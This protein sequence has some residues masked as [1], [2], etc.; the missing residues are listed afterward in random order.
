MIYCIGDS[1]VGLFGGGFSGWSRRGGLTR[2]PYIYS[3]S[4][5]FAT[6]YM[7]PLLA[8]NFVA[9]RRE[10]DEILE[11]FTVGVKVILVFGE[12]DCRAHF[13]KHCQGDKSIRGVVLDCVG[14]FGPSLISLRD[15]GFKV[16][17]W[18]P[19]CVPGA[20]PWIGDSYIRRLEIVKTFNSEVALFC[21]REGLEFFTIAGILSNLDLAVQ[22]G[23]F[24]DAVHLSAKALD[25]GDMGHLIRCKMGELECVY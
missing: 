15:R 3:S 16:G 6:V 20:A 12:I 25:L 19:H 24:D 14:R 8:Y 23:Y 13:P 18:G 7:G 10:F 2:F 22:C 5:S 17:V 11:G 21:E 1:H 9:G 4:F